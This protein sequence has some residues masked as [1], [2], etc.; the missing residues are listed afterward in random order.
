MCLGLAPDSCCRDEDND[1]AVE[2]EN[3]LSRSGVAL[4]SKLL[5]SV[6]GLV[7]FLSRG[8]VLRR[9][10][11]E[12]F[13]G[14]QIFVTPEAGLR[15]WYTDLRRVDGMLFRMARELVA[16]N[17]VVWDIGANVGLFSFSAA[18]L[19]GSNGLV[20]AVEPD[21]WLA[22]LV[23]RSARTLGAR[24]QPGAPISTLCAAVSERNSISQLEIADRARSANHLAD[25]DGS[26]QSGGARNLQ[27][28]VTLSLDFLLDFF[29]S[30]NVLKIDVEAAE[31]RVLCGAHKL[32][33][34]V[35]PVIW[36]EV[37]PENQESVGEL[38]RANG[39]RVYAAALEPAKRTELRRASWDTLAIPIP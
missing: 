35:R 14:A 34:T 10:L 36:C 24:S 21:L 38:L 33:R 30:P 3:V 4:R 17:H 7:E 11:P 28:T 15:Y 6:R 9:Q 5:M 25:V 13:G 22:Q 1:Q 26:T 12:E 20:L 18:A 32:L 39:Y 31:F 16:V 2:L 37:A 8:I 29:P 19:A 27:H 23:A